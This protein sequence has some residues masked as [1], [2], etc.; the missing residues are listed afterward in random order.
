MGKYGCDNINDNGERLV[1]LCGTNNLVIGGTIF[2]HK[3]I[4]KLTWISP[5]GRDKNQIDHIIINGKW[6]RSLQN[7]RVMRG[8]DVASDHHLVN[9]KLKLKKTSTHVNVERI[10]DV[11]KLQ[12]PKIQQEFK[13]E[14]QNR[15]Q[16][17]ENLSTADADTL[18]VTDEW[19]KLHKIYTEASEKV[20]GFKRQVHKEWIT[21]ETWKLID[22]RKVVINNICQTHTERI[23][24]KLR[25]KYTEWNKKV[26]TATRKTK[27][28]FMED[29]ARKAESAAS[30][31]RMGQIYHVTKQLSGKEAEVNM[32]I[33][34][35]DNNTLTTER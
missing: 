16:L 23:K 28:D 8:A 2:P 26:K 24:E 29:L 10:F 31:Q 4:H 19:K 33:K 11:G 25:T 14:I 6:R 34:D 9:I 32:T 7:V 20:L 27:R 1:D 18:P 30:N 22:E 3:E 21:P 13:L 12:D 35:K 5:N 17:L 15:F